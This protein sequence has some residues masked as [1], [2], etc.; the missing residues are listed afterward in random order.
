MQDAQQAKVVA[1]A[2]KEQQQSG[3]Q[4]DKCRA[5]NS[6]EGQRCFASCQRV[7][8]EG[9]DPCSQEISEVRSNAPFCTHHCTAA[10]L[11]LHK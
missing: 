5:G 2:K 9:R 3:F 6:S 7:S 11:I 1:A 10:S 8:A 4:S